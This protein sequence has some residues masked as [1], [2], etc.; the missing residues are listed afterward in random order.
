MSGNSLVVK[1]A[2]KFSVNE[3][4][5]LQT[6]KQTCFQGQVSDAQMTALLV[7]ADQY[8]LNPFTKEIYAFPDKRG[9]IVPVVGIDGWS[10]I[11]NEHPMFDGVEFNMG[12][13][14]EN[15][16][17]MECVLFR[18]DRSHPIRIREYMVEVARQT[19]PWRTHPRRMLRH[20]SLIQCARIAFGFVGIYDEDEAARILEKDITPRP[21]RENAVA[22]AQAAQ[23]IEVEN[24]EE[25]DRLLADFEAIADNGMD[26][27]RAAWEKLSPEEKTLHGGISK[28]TKARAKQADDFNKNGAVSV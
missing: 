2:S 22:I 26:A 11:I 23:I 17:W 15:G 25:R 20:K 14:E 27:L 18:K 19:D 12:R 4:D 5:V 21:E 24:T 10:R 3:A 1:F 13:D 8:S 16:A 9:G 28:A 7:V 6:L